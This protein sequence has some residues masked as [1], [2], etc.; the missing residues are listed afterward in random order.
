MARAPGRNP[1]AVRRSS[2]DQESRVIFAPDFVI[3]SGNRE[4]SRVH[5]PRCLP[6][7]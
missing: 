4:Q 1:G 2:E 3:R 6:A 7:V 5:Q